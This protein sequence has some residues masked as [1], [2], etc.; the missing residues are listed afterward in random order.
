MDK[1]IL[2]HKRKR[3]INNV[4][5]ETPVGH[6]YMSLMQRLALP[7]PGVSASKQREVQYD[8]FCPKVMD[9]VD[10]R[11]CPDCSLYFPFVASMR[12]HKK[13]VR[14]NCGLIDNEVP[15]LSD[16]HSLQ[17]DG[18]EEIEMS[19]SIEGGSNAMLVYIFEAT[20]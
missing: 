17:E 10:A 12:R 15:H 6:Q 5:P 14:Q 1:V 20:R 11:T 3:T 2:Q 9:E 16:E 18:E 8:K 7:I 19:P 13:G 4:K